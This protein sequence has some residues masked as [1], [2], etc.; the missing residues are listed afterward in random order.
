MLTFRTEALRL[1]SN[2]RLVNSFTVKGMANTALPCS[3]VVVS[4]DALVTKAP[5]ISN[6]DGK[7]HIKK[8]KSSRTSLIGYSGF[9]PREWLLIAWGADTCVSISRTK[10]ISRNQARAISAGAHLV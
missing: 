6:I 8:L 7:C 1:V 4:H 10:T 3:S 5:P 2:V 9:I